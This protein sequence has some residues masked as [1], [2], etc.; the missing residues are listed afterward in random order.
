[1]S[2][3]A[4]SSLGGGAALVGQESWTE[5]GG[6]QLIR[7]GHEWRIGQVGLLLV[8]RGAAKSNG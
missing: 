8:F 7:G 2:V 6:G 3:G 4:V 5:S 1:M